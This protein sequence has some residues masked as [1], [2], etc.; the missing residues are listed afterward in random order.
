MNYKELLKDAYKLA[1]ESP[2]TSTQ[3]GS[4]IVSANNQ[5]EWLTRDFNRPTNGYTMLEEDWER[6][7]KYA[8][9]EHSERNSIYKAAS[10]GISTQGATLVASWAA[11]QDCARAIV[12]SGIHTLIRHAPPQ[13]EASQRWL[14]SVLVGDDI[15]KAGSVTILDV[16][17][18][19]LGAPKILR[20]SEWFDPAAG[21]N[22]HNHIYEEG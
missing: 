14:E 10:Y 13:D 6:P 22:W 3:I 1:S 11:C 12:Q 20:S 17:G 4:F 19:I 9:L 16:F 8:L 5:I 2:D 18:P 15:L 21:D 7:R